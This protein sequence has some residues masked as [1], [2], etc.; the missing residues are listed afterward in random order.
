[1]PLYFAKN[2][3]FSCYDMKTEA[4]VPSFTNNDNYKLYNLSK[5][6][7]ANNR[8]FPVKALGHS[9]KDTKILSDDVFLTNRIKKGGIG[10]IIVASVDDG[11]VVKRLRLSKKKGVTKLISENECYPDIDDEGQELRFWGVAVKVVREY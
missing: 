7:M 4:G 8:H 6:F 10:D 1:M 3:P 11:A 5:K 2:L 9:M